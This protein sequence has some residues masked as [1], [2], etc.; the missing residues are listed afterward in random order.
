MNKPPPC[1][2]KPGETY[3]S[4]YG[5]SQVIHMSI[6]KIYKFHK[7]ALMYKSAA[8]CAHAGCL[9]VHAP[10]M[11]SVQVSPH[12]RRC[13]VVTDFGIRLAKRT[14]W[15]WHASKR[16]QTPQF[17][18]GKSRNCEEIN[19]KLTFFLSWFLDRFYWLTVHLVAFN[20]K[21]WAKIVINKTLFVFFTAL[22]FIVNKDTYLSIQ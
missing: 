16:R 20:N 18:I 6:V 9:C 12:V 10:Q 22:M 21:L 17:D 15:H 2:N 13:I 11:C 14:C 19:P 7:W 1:D 3:T 5:N 8:G 4:G